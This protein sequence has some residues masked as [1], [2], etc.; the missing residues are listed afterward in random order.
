MPKHVLM[1]DVVAK[2]IFK[3]SSVGKELT[4]RVVSEILKEDFNTIYN[5]IRLISEEVA[6]SSLTVNS[7]TDIMLEENSMYVDIEICYSK[8][9]TRQVQTDSYLYQIFLGQIKSFREYKKIKKIIQILIEDYDYFH[10]N[11]FIYDV[12]YMEKNLKTIEDETIEKYH[13]NLVYLE[14]LG[15]NKIIQ[16]KDRLIK[17]LYFLI[18]DSDKLDDIYRGDIF[19]EKVVKEAKEIAGLEDIKLYF[20]EDE[21]LKYDKEIEYNR[22]LEKGLKEGHEKGIQEGIEQNKQEMVINMFNDKLPVETIMKYANLTK[23]E[24]EKIINK[25]NSE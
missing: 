1:N 3:N 8:G 11:K 21:I 24:V 10:E 25:K 7:T 18:C 9:S 13:V 23:E 17:L 19:M 20:T 15:Y 2:K 5:N 16:E 22:G 14:K 4:A 12:V 6:F